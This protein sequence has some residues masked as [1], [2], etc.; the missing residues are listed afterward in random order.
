[1]ECE[2]AHI[3]DIDPWRQTAIVVGATLYDPINVYKPLAANIGIVD[4]PF[5]YFSVAGM[6]MPM[7]FT[8]RMTVVRLSNGELF[9]HSPIAFDEGLAAGLA[10]MGTIRHFVSPNQWHYAHV[11]EWQRAFPNA[12]VWGTRAAERRAR[13]RRTPVRFTRYLEPDPPPE[14]SEDFDQTFLPSGIFGEFIFFHRASATL[15]LTDT[16]MNLEPGKTDQPWLGFA[17]LTGMTAPKGGMFFGMR[18]PLRLQ[19]KKAEATFATIRSIF[20]A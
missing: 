18:L 15:I 16:I 20:D 2:L 17:R 7:P 19:R 1:M 5:E 14:W 6:R 4:G 11:G 9:L 10:R 3:A 8:T 13:A 12:T